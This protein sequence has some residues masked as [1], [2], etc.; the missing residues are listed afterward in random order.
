MRLSITNQ[1]LAL[2]K[3]KYVYGFFHGIWLFPAIMTVILI[4]LSSL[5]LS[6][7]SIGLYHKIFYGN[8]PD[9]ALIAN[10]PESIRSDEWIVSSQKAIAQ[11][12]NNFATVNNNIGNGEDTTLLA[13]M[14]YRDWSIIFKPHNIG[15]L[16][17]PFDNAFALHWWSMSYFL[18]LSAYFFM[19]TLLP[20]R[21]LLAAILSLG[22]L[23]SPFFQWWYVYGALGSVY[24][25][26]FGATVLINL[27]HSNKKIK[28][29]LWSVALSYV[30]ISFALI[31]Y[32]PFQI[33]AA[34]VIGVF[35]AGYLLNE[36]KIINKKVV[37]TN[38]LFF[39]SAVVISTA[40]VGIFLYQKKD[41]VNTIQNT[42]Y[43]GQR[44]V[45][46]G[47]YN[48]EHLLSSNLSPVFQSATK[49]ASY[50]R[51]EIGATNTS[52]SSNF[53]LI[54]PML[55]L[56]LGYLSY[57]QWRQ[58]RHL[59]YTTLLPVALGL[60][61]IAWMLVPGLEILGKVT[62]LDKVPQARLLV[63]FGLLNFIFIILYIK[64]Y[65]ESKYRFPLRLS[66]PYALLLIIFYLLL[67]FHVLAK[68]P[69]FLTFSFATLLALPFAAIVF[70]FVRKY[71][72]LGSIALLLFSLLSVYR[73]NPL[74]QGTA[75]L[76]DSP[77]SQAI[78]SIG[79]NSQNKWVSDSIIIENF[80]TMNGERSL[81]GTYTYP[82]NKLWDGLGQQ[83]QRDIY[84]RYAHVSFTF[85]RNKDNVITPRLSQ[86]TADQFN[87]LL[88]PC[89]DFFKQTDVGFLITTKPFEDGEATCSSMIQTINYPA[90]TFYIYRLYF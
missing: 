73:I 72:I 36:R 87:V 78:R 85:D 1:L 3:S 49:A 48:L 20:R 21:Q 30:A 6:G 55:L 64:T 74:Y 32:P 63:G 46:S 16:A 90:I 41:I 10:Q 61:F 25:A 56:P 27:I 39:A 15:F 22:L 44:V 26:L 42:A 45:K 5:Q 13:D 7:S 19:I 33:P 51:P 86:P 70:L 17:L 89:N 59:D 84:N 2:W 47:V 60:V 9:K 31:L 66:L 34:L 88:E 68:F 35:L 58:K 18:V 40:T 38:L 37:K 71:F 77:I 69:G 82:Q 43:P 23:F 53:I 4:T 83:S 57:R 8:Q 76:T 11:K 62:L 14:P 80:A 52:E 67:D 12:N 75:I 79:K 29:L 24:Y 54:L 81:T 65:S 28:S 50:A